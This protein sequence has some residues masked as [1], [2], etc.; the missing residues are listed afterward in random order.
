M[1]SG[2]TSVYL[3][4]LYFPVI[5]LCFLNWSFKELPFHMLC[6]LPCLFTR[7]SKT[8]IKRIWH[9]SLLC[10][11]LRY[12]GLRTVQC[13]RQRGCCIPLPL[14][15]RDALQKSL[16]DLQNTTAM[17]LKI[18]QVRWLGD[19]TKHYFRTTGNFHETR[20][21][22]EKKPQTPNLKNIAGYKLNVLV[23]I[24]GCIGITELWENLSTERV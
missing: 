9:K 3:N 4:N 10:L 8:N 21:D 2:R 6:I 16:D 11:V 14:R 1:W 18:C 12:Q 7:I 5:I 19:C 15:Y 13:H 22:V 17:S 20:G 23:N 24:Y